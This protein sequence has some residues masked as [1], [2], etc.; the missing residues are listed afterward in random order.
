MADT[1]K[2]NVKALAD[3]VE[4]TTIESRLTALEA[5]VADLR[6]GVTSSIDITIVEKMHELVAKWNAIAINGWRPIEDF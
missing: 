1:K 5:E 6:M 4:P 3:P 2:D